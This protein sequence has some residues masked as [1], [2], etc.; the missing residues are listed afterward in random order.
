MA[1]LKSHPNKTTTG[2][3]YVDERSTLYYSKYQY[4]ARLSLSGLNR[5]YS[6]N[7]FLEY[8]KIIERVKRNKSSNTPLSSMLLDELQDVDLDS[9]ER[10]ITWRN[11]IAR[12]KGK[13]ALIRVEHNTAGVFSN[14]LQLLKTLEHI[15]PGLASIDYTEVDQSIPTGTKYYVKEPKHKYRVYLKSKTV[16]PAWKLTISRFI[17]R[18]KGTDT[19]VNP[20]VSL[21]SWLDAKHTRNWYW[22]INYCSSHYFIDFNDDSMNSMFALMFGDMISRRF[23]LEKRP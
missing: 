15:A 12:G 11:T 5:T 17:D 1:S 13:Q 9:I 21:S 4:R 6:A 2:V 23:K 10:Y 7:T 16:E 8:L 18:Y 19:I 22:N 14:D 3:D 20:S